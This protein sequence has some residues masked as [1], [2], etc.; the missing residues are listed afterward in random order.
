M[1]HEQHIK[2]GARRDRAEEG[3]PKVIVCE[4]N[5]ERETVPRSFTK[6][7]ARMTLPTSVRLKPVSIMTA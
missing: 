2:F 3:Q 1:L 7:A 6:H 4:D 5:A